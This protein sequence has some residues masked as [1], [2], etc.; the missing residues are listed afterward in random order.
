MQRMEYT[1]MRTIRFEGNELELR[2]RLLR[3]ILINTATGA[4][5]WLV[6]GLLGVARSRLFPCDI[7]AVLAACV[8]GGVLLRYGWEARVASARAGLLRSRAS[9]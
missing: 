5:I 9:R 4:S 8:V 1:R 3:A 2:A 6:A 7:L